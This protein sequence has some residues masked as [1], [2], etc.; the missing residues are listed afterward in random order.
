MRLRLPCT[1]R[2]CLLGLCLSHALQPTPV[3]DVFRRCASLEEGKHVALRVSIRGRVTESKHV[4]DRLMFLR[5]RDE[6]C[7][8]DETCEIELLLRERDGFLSRDDLQGIVGACEATGAEPS[9]ELSSEL[10]SSSDPATISVSNCV[11]GCSFDL[12]VNPAC[13]SQF[14]SSSCAAVKRPLL[15]AAMVRSVSLPEGPATART[16]LRSRVRRTASASA[17]EVPPLLTRSS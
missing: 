5:L 4:S 9:S 3:S 16:N 7:G 6:V 17:A 12:R 11:P 10:S 13:T 1:V 15:A 14:H 2:L 8:R